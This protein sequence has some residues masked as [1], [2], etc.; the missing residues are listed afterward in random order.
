MEMEVAMVSGFGGFSSANDVL[1]NEYVPSPLDTLISPIELILTTTG[2]CPVQKDTLLLTVEPAPIVSA[3]ADQTHCANN[4]IADLAG[5][6]TGGSTTGIWTSDGT[7][8]FSPDN[9]TLLAQYIPS[10][11][12]ISSGT[13]EL[14]LTSTNFGS[15]VA[16]TD[17]MILTYTPEP[18]VDAGVDTIYVC[19]NNPI[20]SLNGTVTGVTTSGKWTSN[21]VGIFSPD[22]LTLNATYTPSPGDLG[23]GSVW[24]YLQSTS[25]VN[26]LPV[27]DSVL[28]EF[29][30]SPVVN[31]GANMLACTNDAGID[32]SG[33]V[34][35][36]T[37]TGIW[38]GGA[39]TYTPSDTDLITSYTPSAGEIS[40]GSVLLVLTSTNNGGCIAENSTVQINFIA[41]PFANF[42]F[43]EECLYD[44]SVFTD[45]SLPGY[46]NID[47]WSWDFGDATATSTD[48]NTT[49][50][51]S[52]PGTYN[53]E[54]II[55]SDAGCSD[56]VVQ[57]VEAFEVPVAD[58]IYTSD[59]PNNQVEVSF[60]DMSTT[61]SDAI[62]FWYY[63]FGGQG[64]IAAEDP[65]QLFSSNGNYTVTHIVSTVNGCSDTTSQVLNIPQ[66]PV[67]GFTYNTP[68]GQN[69]GAIFNFINTSSDAINYTW[70]FGNGN[71]SFEE[72]PSNT[73]FANGDYIV[74]QYVTSAFGCVDSTSQ[75]ITINTV[76]IDI[77]ELIPNAISPNEDGSNDVWKLDFIDIL[78]PDAH[79]EI[80]NE[81]GQQLF[82]SDGY[83]IP[84]DGKYN[85]ELVPDGNYF[86]IIDLKGN[87]AK[88]DI[89]K[90]V[91]LVLKSKN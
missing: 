75:M 61:T 79:V 73:Y 42:N 43:T 18:V 11:A 59:C 29:T 90:G 27:F 64:N 84:W 15:C 46:G 16:E 67:A 39:G 53:V 80:Y 19:E 52:A 49:H 12:D 65:T 57:A 3:S 40:A 82:V 45:F 22:N 2:P 77:Y 87:G 9:T 38:T 26:C 72:N 48:Q 74:T 81:W 56:T 20:A 24:L 55:T 28:I 47:S 91:L 32:L 63:D 78:Y 30:P 69:I 21:G 86:Y 6:V 5:T 34:S 37:T 23:A 68:A 17:T 35:G 62:N 76:T 70:E 50:N 13:V 8:T 58:F 25:N 51:Y 14:V 85:G 10:A 66:T 54:L 7:G 60:E 89:H 71:G 44:E 33:T 88:D 41:P 31:A 4:A 83:E 1:I 36:G